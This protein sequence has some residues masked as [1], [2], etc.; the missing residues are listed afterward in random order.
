[1][2]HVATVDCPDR[3]SVD[4]AVRA[5]HDSISIEGH[6][7]EPCKPRTRSTSAIAHVD[8]RHSSFPRPVK[9]AH[10]S[11]R[12]RRTRGAGLYR[13]RQRRLRA[14]SK[15]RVSALGQ[16]IC[17]PPLA[18]LPDQAPRI[19]TNSTPLRRWRFMQSE[20]GEHDRR[21]RPPPKNTCH[22]ERCQRTG[23][24]TRGGRKSVLQ[25][26]CVLHRKTA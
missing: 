7:T 14:H 15:L 17:G 2:G 21:T 25:K 10:H 19:R 24:V 3:P 5:F 26:F 22:F 4:G 23:G 9:V 6:A 12:L 18:R 11:M 8:A 16:L 20:Q 1:L 13:L